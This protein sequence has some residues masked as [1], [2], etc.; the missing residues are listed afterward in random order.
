MCLFVCYDFV[1]SCIH[2]LNHHKQHQFT[3]KSILSFNYDERHYLL[4][5][6]FEVHPTCTCH[7]IV[8]A[9]L[10]RSECGTHGQNLGFCM[11]TPTILAPHH[12]PRPLNLKLYRPKQG[13]ILRLCLGNLG[14]EWDI[15]GTILPVSGQLATMPHALTRDSLALLCS[16]TVLVSPPFLCRLQWVEGWKFGSNAG[17]GVSQVRARTV[18]WTESSS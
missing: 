3:R 8:V 2:L 16:P 15:S 9:N 5:L 4:Q 14:Q 6:L 11:A 12:L 13:S 1:L 7:P 10:V 17:I 18:S